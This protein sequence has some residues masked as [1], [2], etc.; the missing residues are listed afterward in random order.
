MQFK[1][2]SL[3]RYVTGHTS[4]PSNAGIFFQLLQR[5]ALEVSLGKETKMA[6]KVLSIA[7]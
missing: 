5:K 6:V 7:A 2:D 4:R 1:F 3:Y